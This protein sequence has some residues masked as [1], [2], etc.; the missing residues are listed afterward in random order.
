MQGSGSGYV[1]MHVRIDVAAQPLDVGRRARV[2][3]DEA[4]VETGDRLRRGSSRLPLCGAAQHPKATDDAAC[5]G[6][7]TVQ[8][9]DWYYFYGG[10]G[11]GGGDD[12][13]DIVAACKK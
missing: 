3:G 1:T 4:L 13:G 6:L 12:D 2:F 11:G 8:C 10:G 5:T 9:R 7:L